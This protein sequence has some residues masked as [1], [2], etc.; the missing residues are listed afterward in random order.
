MITE[1][2]TQRFHS[3]RQIYAGP[4]S[5]WEA[6]PFELGTVY[7]PTGDIREASPTDSGH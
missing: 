1:T 4:G 3:P 7:R 5:V 2:R 6:V